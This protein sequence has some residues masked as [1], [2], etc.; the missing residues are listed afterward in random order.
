[1]E[2]E[3]DEYRREELKYILKN[4]EKKYR[5]LHMPT[6]NKQRFDDIKIKEF[7]TD[8]KG[9]KIGV[10]IDIKEYTRLSKILKL[11]PQNESWLYENEYALESVHKGL[12]D[13]A[14]GKISKLDLKKL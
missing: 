13:A 12:Q 2:K 14:Q 10:T 4:Y 8:T 1:M 5:G 3:V 9:K 7:V 11:I 6:T